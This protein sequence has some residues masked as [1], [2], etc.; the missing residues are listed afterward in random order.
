MQSKRKAK[1]R[2]AA[3][4][5]SL[6]GLLGSM[7]GQN[8]TDK[9]EAGFQTPPNSAKPRLHRGVKIPMKE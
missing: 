3:V 5:L 7:Y 8:S 1:L 6:T 9:L 4:V 2:I